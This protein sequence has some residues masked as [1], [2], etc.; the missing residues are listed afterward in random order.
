MLKLVRYAPS[1]SVLNAVPIAGSR[2]PLQFCRYRQHS[3]RRTFEILPKDRLVDILYDT[4]QRAGVEYLIIDVR[5]PDDYARLHIKTAIN[6][7]STDIPNF[8][9]QDLVSNLVP[10]NDPVSDVPVSHL[11]PHLLIFHCTLSLIRGPKSAQHVLDSLVEM[12]PMF[13]QLLK[14]IEK[15]EQVQFKWEIPKVAVLQGGFK[16]WQGQYGTDKRLVEGS[17]IPS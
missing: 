16:E 10:P 4:K 13:V 15:T 9:F 5:E 11:L 12:S 17:S 8:S 6:I 2:E 14:D 1:R 3:T 7:P